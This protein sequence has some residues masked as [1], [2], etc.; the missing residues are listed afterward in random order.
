M[1][2]CV[3]VT[4]TP[5]DNGLPGQEARLYAYNADGIDRV[6]FMVATNPGEPLKPLAKIASTGELSRFTLALKGALAEAD[7]IPVLIFDEID[8]GVGGRSGE[9]V[10]KKIWGLARH[11][12][13]VCVT[14]LPQIAVY[15]DAHFGV[16]KETSG[17]RTISQ[18]EQLDSEARLKE[19]ALMLAG[20]GYSA[21]ALENA[22][23]LRQNAETWKNG[24]KHCPAKSRSTPI[25]TNI[26]RTCPRFKQSCTAIIDFEFMAANK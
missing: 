13:V 15:A 25:L 5:S 8:I 21:A 9:I 7:Q 1:D 24:S 26:G 11:H 12:Q 18:L 22:R 14:H 23:E 16:H 4:Q 19:I 3:S 10:G 20:P 2:F 17:E 6:E